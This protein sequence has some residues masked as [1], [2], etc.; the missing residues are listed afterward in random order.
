MA[1]ETTPTLKSSTIERLKFAAGHVY[2]DKGWITI[3]RIG[4][5]TGDIREYVPETIESVETLQYLGLTQHAALVAFGDFAHNCECPKYVNTR[6]I[7][8][9]KTHVR[10]IPDCSK[11]D[12]VPEWDEAMRLMGLQE[13]RRNAI[14]NPRF[15]KIRQEHTARYWVIQT[16]EEKWRHLVELD[17][18]M[19]SDLAEIEAEKHRTK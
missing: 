2:I 10:M 13:L 16:M 9:A 4:S 12:A 11:H 17:R 14:L 7:E 6:F 15:A 5:E 3:A 18:K 1:F 8:W 19:K